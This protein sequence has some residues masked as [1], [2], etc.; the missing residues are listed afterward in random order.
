MGHYFLDTQYLEIKHYLNLFEIE[1]RFNIT[2][3]LEWV[4]K[5]LKSSRTISRLFILTKKKG[6]NFSNICYEIFF[7]GGEGLLREKKWKIKG[8]RNKNGNKGNNLTSY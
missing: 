6:Y 8:Q 5:E 2:Y 4:H 3:T 7:G 1:T